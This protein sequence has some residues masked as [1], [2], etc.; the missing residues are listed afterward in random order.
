MKFFNRRNILVIATL[1][2]LAAAAATFL[3]RTP[4]QA[5]L[6]EQ[7][8]ADVGVVSELVGVAIVADGDT[9]RIGN[10]HIRFDGIDAPAQGHMCGDVNIYRASGDALRAVTTRAQVRC[11][12]SDQPDAKGRDMAQCRAGDLDLNEYMVREGW[13]RDWP[14]H[15]GGAY[16][17]EEAEARAAQRGVW[18][19]SCP[20]N[21]WTEG[22]DYGR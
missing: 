6:P 4:R 21:I 7:A 19:P 15:S 1:I 16:A 10:R 2:A 12:I 8:R 11:R 22:R 13:A 14:L 17:D 20:R 9:I 18:S 5:A 3:P